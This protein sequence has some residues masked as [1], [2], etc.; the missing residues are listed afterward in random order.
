MIIIVLKNFIVSI[1]VQVECIK[2]FFK[3]KLETN[4]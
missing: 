4:I 2:F 3:K 1:T